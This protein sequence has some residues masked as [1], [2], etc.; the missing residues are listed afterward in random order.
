[1]GSLFSDSFPFAPNHKLWDELYNHVWLFSPGF[2]AR[3]KTP[4]VFGVL[5]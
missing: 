4:L 5:L 1:L 2:S 3:N